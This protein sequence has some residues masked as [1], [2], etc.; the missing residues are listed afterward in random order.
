[1]NLLVGCSGQISIGHA[2]F[3][4]F[5][6]FTS[7]WLARSGVPVLFAIPLAGFATTVVGLTF[8]LPAARIRGLYLAIATLSA[9]YILQDFFNRATWFTGGSAGTTAETPVV[10]GLRLAGDSRYFY[11]VLVWLV[12]ML[13]MAAN[14]L[15]TRTGRALIAVRDHHIAAE[16]MGINL[17]RYRVLAFGL[18]A[19]CAGIGGALYAHHLGFVSAE[20][21]NLLLSVQFLAM[22]II[23][24]LGSLSGTLLGAAFMVLLPEAMSAIAGTLNDSAVGSML[25]LGDGI[26]F[27]REMAIGAAIIVFL[28]FEPNGLVHR[29][30]RLRIQWTIILTK[31]R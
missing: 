19:F 12:V 14:L 1:L 30:D 21:F 29:W 5:G 31:R 23:G 17:T 25:N 26:A 10:F 20:S 18:A 27:L 4:G 13:A 6:A 28:L 24:G 3:F 11:L 9:Q 8:G 22:I 2:A 15:R 7:A 16:M